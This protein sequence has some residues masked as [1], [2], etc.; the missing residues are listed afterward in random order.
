MNPKLQALSLMLPLA[1][2]CVSPPARAGT[3]AAPSPATTSSPVPPTATDTPR[4]PNAAPNAALI[5]RGYLETPALFRAAAQRINP[6]IVTIESF[7]G[8]L[9]T[10]P[11]A[12]GKG[13]TKGGRRPPTV[14]GISRPGEGPTTGLI[15]A[16]DASD[17]LILTS[18]YNFLRDPPIITVT[19]ADASTHVAKLLGRDDTRKLC[20]LRI[21]PQANARPA[22]AVPLNEIRVGQWALSLGVGYGGDAPAVSAGIVSATGRIFGRAIQ[23]D[24]NISPA[25][26]GGPLIDLQGRVIGLCVPLSPQDPSIAAGVEWYDSGIGFAIPLDGLAPVLERLKRGESLRSGILGIQAK[27]MP[28]AKAVGVLKVAPDSG[29]ARAGLQP[30]DLIRSV[31]GKDVASVEDLKLALARSL[32]GETIDLVIERDGRRIDLRVTLTPP[33][34]V[35]EAPQ[36][37][38]AVESPKPQPQPAPPPQALPKPPG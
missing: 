22:P 1:L 10:A 16:S 33:P 30:G 11:P 15:I 9:P 14:R 37:P 35:P 6:S 8:A 34:S 23:T 12:P 18:T 17:T 26:Y 32:A 31:A 2:A 38:G 28:L 7:G 4:D 24:A 3:D 20:L 21:A 5:A 25:N 36:G 27:S 29:G 13:P 19:L